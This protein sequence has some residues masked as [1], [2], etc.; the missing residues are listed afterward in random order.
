MLYDPKWDGVSLRG[1]IGWLET[2]D[3][4]DK[5]DFFECEGRCLLGQYMEAMNIAWTGA[6][7]F[8]N[9]DWGKS[10]YAKTA[11]KIFGEGPDVRFNALANRPH[12]FGAALKRA[13]KALK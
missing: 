2:K 4:G 9:G 12:T 8:P 11:R 7:D 3:P 1:F 10:S 13:R 6:P 5:Y